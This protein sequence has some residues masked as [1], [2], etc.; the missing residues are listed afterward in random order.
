[1]RAR[2]GLRFADWFRRWP[3][4]LRSRIAQASVLVALLIVLAFVYRA[5]LADRLWPETRAQALREAAAAA[6]SRGHL[7]AAD[8]SG[9]RELYAAALA[10]DPDR[11]EARA[12]LQR[13]AQAALVQARQAIRAQR[14]EEA[15]RALRLARTLS[16]PAADAQAVA[17]LLRER[18]AAVAGL[19]EVLARAERARAEGRLEE[20]LPLYRRVL[21]L[22]PNRTAAL[23][24]REDALSDLLQQADA[25]IAGGRLV[26]AA[27]LV[28]RAGEFDAGH[29][30]LPDTRAALAR[31][32]DAR[33]DAATRASRRGALREAARSFQALLEIDAGDDAA[34][35]G[36]RQ[37]AAAH[38]RRS[39]RFAADFRFDAAARE[40]ER[41]RV[42]AP[43]AAETAQAARRLAQAR[44]SQRQLPRPLADPARLRALLAQVE[45]ARARGDLM[46]PPG[47]SA[48]DYLRAARAQAPRDPAV[49]AATTRL[50]AAAR[51]C[52]ERELTGNRLTRAHACLDARI[53][54]GAGDLR[55]ERR[56]LA[57]RWVA[58]GV[59]RLG[60]GELAVA[61][62]AA[63]AARALDAGAA[64]LAAFE[65]RL[66]AAEAASA[67]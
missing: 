44:R 38:A 41:A 58:V 1:M 60:A 46:Q 47:E 50:L 56:R 36:L 59:E 6:L 55:D 40:L 22:Q 21:S 27:A 8:G 33:R 51:E 65:Q 17:T 37:V 54:L 3:P 5:P 26:E 61:R 12:G 57:T 10:L 23:E 42:L 11:L 20:A 53:Q 9:A 45:Q 31:A 35:A 14:F 2:P 19:D 43:D 24:G 64:G 16:V 30:A 34:L 49:A 7:T 29:V 66:R 28:A 4:A 15:H 63:T 13:V 25:H 18:E 67:R 52:F 39:E 48:Y 62:R 32:I